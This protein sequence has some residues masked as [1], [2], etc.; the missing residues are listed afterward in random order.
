M[1]FA[2]FSAAAADKTGEH[3]GKLEDLIEL[4]FQFI[5]PE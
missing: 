1:H 3:L 5:G 4:V 2:I